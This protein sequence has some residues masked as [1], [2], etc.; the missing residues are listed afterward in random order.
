MKEKKPCDDIFEGLP[1]LLIN[2][3]RVTSEYHRRISMFERPASYNERTNDEFVIEYG[4]YRY[5]IEKI[6][7]EV[8]SIRRSMIEEESEDD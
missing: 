1:E 7:G 4:A 2:N 6:N 5:N 8:I 3:G